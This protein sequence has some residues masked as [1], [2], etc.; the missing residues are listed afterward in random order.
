MFINQQQ[1]WTTLNEE[2]NLCVVCDVLYSCFGD[3]E[4]F[5]EYKALA[6]TH[7]EVTGYAVRDYLLNTLSEFER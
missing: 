1:D 6:E 5:M 7:P 4:F 3:A 2:F